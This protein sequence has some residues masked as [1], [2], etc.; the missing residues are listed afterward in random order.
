[1][2]HHQV[3]ARSTANL[4]KKALPMSGTG[5]FITRKGSTVAK[6]FVACGDAHD[7]QKVSKPDSVGD[8]RHSPDVP[9]MRRPN[10]SKA[11]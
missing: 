11:H 3:A 8:G 7:S 10:V 5:P 4:C 6:S 2:T 1:M 9:R